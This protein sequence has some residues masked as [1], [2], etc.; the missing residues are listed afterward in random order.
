DTRL[1]PDPR[2]IVSELGIERRVIFT[3]WIAEEDKPALYSGALLFVFLSIYEGFG[4]MPLEAMSCGT[5]VLVSRAAS[6]P[7]IVGQGGWLVDPTDLEEVTDAMLTLLRDPVLR[8]QLAQNA[9]MRAS[10]FDWGKTAEQTLAVYEL[11][12]C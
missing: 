11:A 10:Q 12:A 6:L 8:Q 4:L 7:E 1:F 2:R 5:P 3:D 9:L